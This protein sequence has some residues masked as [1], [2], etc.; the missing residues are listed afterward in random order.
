LSVVTAEGLRVAT[1]LPVTTVGEM[2]VLTGQPRLATVEAVKAARIL[3]IKK[4]LFDMLLHK[5]QHI[6]SRIYRNVV[7][8]LAEKLVNDNVHLR[9]YQIEKNLSSSR[10]R[11]LEYQ[12][13]IQQRRLEVLL[14]FMEQQGFVSQV[15][16]ERHIEEKMMEH[17]S[18]V[19]IVDDEADFR[20]L[21]IN[22]LPYFAVLEAG[23]GREALEVIEGNPPDLVITD[24]NM[25]EMDGFALLKAL[26]QQHPDL[27]VL[28]VSGYV[29]SAEIEDHGFNGIIRKPLRL[30]NFRELIEQALGLND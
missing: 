11:T 26:R 6:S 23:N 22:A 9:D 18:R 14:E 28:A 13:E 12:V 8:I 25:P 10:V 24:I 7:H 5:D 17:A 15:E 4:R 21:V 1:I 2:G 16:T 20:H 27:P 29:E 30:K 3:T 19:L